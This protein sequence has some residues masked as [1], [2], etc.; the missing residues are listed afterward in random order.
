MPIDPPMSYTYEAR[1]EEEAVRVSSKLRT[2][3]RRLVM[4][5]IFRY[6]EDRSKHYTLGKSGTGI[7][8][9]CST[10]ER[11]LACDDANHD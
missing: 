5:R 2:V 4:Y 3:L 9:M 10:E 6:I 1:T 11:S 8:S 7:K